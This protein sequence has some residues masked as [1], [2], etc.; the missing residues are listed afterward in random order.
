[1]SP[2]VTGSHSVSPAV[3]QTDPPSPAQPVPSPT[4]TPKGVATEK[5]VAPVTTHQAT[6]D[7]IW[8]TWL[9]LKGTTYVPAPKG[10]DFK[11]VKELLAAG[12]TP[13]AVDAAWSRALVHVGFP[14]VSTVVELQAHYGKFNG[15]GPPRPALKNAPT[16]PDQDFPRGILNANPV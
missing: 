14:S 5:P 10:A 4:P 1:M 3:T 2:A 9:R 12:Q 13:E 6:V 11:A 15:A 16:N 8:A 7:R